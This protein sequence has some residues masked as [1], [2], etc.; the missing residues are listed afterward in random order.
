MEKGTLSKIIFIE[1]ILIGV[2]SLIIGVA[3]GVVLSQALSI[4]TAYMFK[5]D[6]TK[7]TFIFS[8]SAFKKTI[9]CFIAIYI[10]VLIFNSI[11][12]KK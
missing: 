9:L 3:L 8:E 2:I 1:T 5:V 10:I 11:K 4:F 7:F 6:L 12:I